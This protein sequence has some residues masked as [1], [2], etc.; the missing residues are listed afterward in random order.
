M[1]HAARG[2]DVVSRRRL[3]AR[4]RRS[5]AD[6]SSKGSR[7][8][9]GCITS[10]NRPGS[11]FEE[12]TSTGSRRFGRADRRGSWRGCNPRGL[13]AH[14]SSILGSL[15]VADCSTRESTV[16]QRN[17]SDTVPTGRDNRIRQNCSDVER[18]GSPLHCLRLRHLTDQDLRLRIS[19]WWFESTRS[20]LVPKSSGEDA[21]LSTAIGEFDPRRDRSIR[22]GLT[23][24]TLA[25]GSGNRGSNPR[26]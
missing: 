11:P 6:Q 8:V 26:A 19:G 21:R 23:G 14:P 9:T 17:D 7:L 22:R 3:C 16:P 12:E 2:T 13:R 4:S 25:S 10:A 5:P 1:R 20:Q 18:H 24:R 15:T